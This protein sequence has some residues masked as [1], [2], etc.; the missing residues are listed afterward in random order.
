MTSLSVIPFRGK[1]EYE[2]DDS[3]VPENFLIPLNFG[4][5]GDFTLS[6]TSGLTG[7]DLAAQG[8]ANAIDDFALFAQEQG[9]ITIQSPPEIKRIGD[10][11][12]GIQQVTDIKVSVNNSQI[13]TS[14]TF[15]TI[16]PRFGKNNK[17]IEK[18]LTKISNRVNK[19]KLI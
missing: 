2:Q 12:Y 8:R 9:S 1:V 4:E 10:S 18:K 11:L 7:L 17:D 13:T 3:L 6:Q 15:K 16:S 14:Y 5:F 19:L